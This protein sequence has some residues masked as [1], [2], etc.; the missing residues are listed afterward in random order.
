MQ[1][2]FFSEVEAAYM[3]SRVQDAVHASSLAA[4]AIPP[5]ATRRHPFIS[6]LILAFGSAGEVFQR[7]WPELHSIPDGK[8]LPAVQG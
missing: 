7:P 1:N 8:E 2:V 3:R 4:Q 5:R 6:S